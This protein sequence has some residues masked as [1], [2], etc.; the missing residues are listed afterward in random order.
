MDKTF[1]CLA[2]SRKVSGRCIAG[3]E[4]TN[5][6]AGSWVRPISER[7]CHEISE[8]D[9]RYDD[10]TMAQIFDIVSVRFKAKAA[11]PAQEENYTIDD[12]YYWSKKGHYSENLDALVDT[13]ATLWT[14][15]HSSYN[16][17][18]DRAPS[19]VIAAPI[20]S[21]YFIS[22]SNL[23]II[24]RIEGAEFN[25]GKKKVRVD[26][27]YNGARHLISCTDPAVEKIYLAQGEGTYELTGNIY[28]TVS[29]GEVWNDYYYKLAAGIFEVK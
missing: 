29:L 9:R 8:I 20:Q 7:D 2:N 17:T 23:K 5:N 25:N 16:G 3:K 4:Y 22:P 14:N 26:F 18:N 21:L 1:I 11:H 24:V 15:G 28:M 19:S 13:P 27:E 6:S 12:D 10:G